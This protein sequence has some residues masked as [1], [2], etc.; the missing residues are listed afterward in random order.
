MFVY[1][2]LSTEQLGTC[3]YLFTLDDDDVNDMNNNDVDIKA[4][5]IGLELYRKN[6]IVCVVIRVI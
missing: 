1:Y 2:T 3:I 6:V 5:M 4:V